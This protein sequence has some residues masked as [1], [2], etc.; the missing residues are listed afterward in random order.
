[1]YCVKVVEKHPYKD[2]YIECTYSPAG[3][4]EVLPSGVL[5]IIMHGAKT[6]IV[7]VRD[8]IKFNVT[9]IGGENES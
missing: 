9:I 6:E 2:K 1:M 5:Q 7:C 4:V 8:Y 3:H